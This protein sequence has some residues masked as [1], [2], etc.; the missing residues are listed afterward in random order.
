VSQIPETVRAAE[1]LEAP[2]AVR[3]L[4]IA[5]TT[6]AR[7]SRA[8]NQKDMELTNNSISFNT[9]RSRMARGFLLAHRRLLAR[10]GNVMSKHLAYA[11][12]AS[13]AAIAS[14]A[15]LAARIGSLTPGAAQALP[16]YARRTGLPCGQ[17]HV[18][19][20]GGG[21]RTAFGRAFAANGHRLPGETQHRDRSDEP[22]CWRGMM[23]GHGPG[24]M[25]G[26][27]GMMGGC[28]D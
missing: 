26:H 8:S 21:P 22:R 4:A 23:G 18:D 28:G 12:L 6:F 27:G 7:G 2:R 10:K 11:F 25:G 16:V 3:R 13:V 24:M 5:A 20:A 9:Q 14:A 17:C 19:P 15:L 1:R